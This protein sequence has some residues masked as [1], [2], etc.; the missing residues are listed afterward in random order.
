MMRLTRWLFSSER[1]EANRRRNAALV[2]SSCYRAAVVM[3]ALFSLAM[4]S[5]QLA[6]QQ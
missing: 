5:T 6:A 4:I 2:R 3:L 1:M